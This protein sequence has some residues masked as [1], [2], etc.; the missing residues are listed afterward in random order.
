[1]ELLRTSRSCAPRTVQAVATSVTP[2]FLIHHAPPNAHSVRKSHR[3]STDSDFQRSGDSNASGGDDDEY[4]DDDYDDDSESVS[5]GT[6]LFALS[7]TEEDLS[8][9]RKGFDK[10]KVLRKTL[11][12]ELIEANNNNATKSQCGDD[13]VQKVVIKK[14]VLSLHRDR[15]GIDDE[16]QIVVDEDIENEAGILRLLTQQKH[17]A[18]G[19]IVKF[20]DFFSSDD[21]HFLV[22]DYVEHSMSLTV[23]IQTIHRLKREGILKKRKMLKII[24]LLFWQLTMALHWLHGEMDCVHLDL[25]SENV[26]VRSNFERTD[27]GTVV[28]HNDPTL[29]LTEF[30]CAQIFKN[31]DFQCHIFATAIDREQ[32]LA[33]EVS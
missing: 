30:G 5:I 27:K 20:V 8:L 18:A 1:L 33:P 10:K 23:Y 9:A 29:S 22:M 7:R 24:K 28:I 21:A 32:Y 2:Q 26:L 15:I 17:S 6:M 16:I 25:C 13:S 31:K 19:Y 4:D 3:G 14:T 11:Q 12:G